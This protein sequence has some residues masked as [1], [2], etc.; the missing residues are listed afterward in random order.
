MVQQV[1]DKYCVC[2]VAARKMCNTTFYG[3]KQG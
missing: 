2:N 1:G 3:A